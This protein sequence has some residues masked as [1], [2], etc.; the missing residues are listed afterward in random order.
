MR[1]ETSVAVAEDPLEVERRAQLHGALLMIAA[2]ALFA[3]MAVCSRVATRTMGSAQLVLV[4]FTI[5]GLGVL[6]FWAAGQMSIA[7]KN[8]RLLALRGLFGGGA[9]LLY[10]IALAKCRDAGTATLLNYVS[11]IF[12]SVFA[13]FF[14]KE[15]PTFRLA[16]G[17]VLAFAGVLLVLRTPQGFTLGPGEIA[18]MCSAVFSGFAVV[19]IRAA[20]GYDNAPTILLAF[21]IGG[22]LIALPFAVPTWVSVT[23]DVWLLAL[24][25]GVTSLFAQLM[26][27]HAFGLVTASHGA[28]FQQL[29]PVFTF[30]LGAALLH[31]EMGWLS[32]IGALLTL[33]AVAY[34][35]MPA[36][37]A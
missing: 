24:A 27:T 8:L 36:R 18:G 9:V 23:G 28:L 12:T 32:V 13:W 6:A 3:V 25:V 11:P 15:R 7:P 1:P 21:S 14:L 30:T 5:T 19:T 37:R 33:S 10:F 22:G 34:A 16:V 17:V 29:T 35:A 2:M 4:R 20:R 31:E 26:M